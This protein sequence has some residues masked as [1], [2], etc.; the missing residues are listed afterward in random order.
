MKKTNPDFLNGV[1]ELLIL[2][3][4]AGQPMHGYDLVQA[5]RDGSSMKLDFGEGSIYPVL[6]RMEE[7]KLLSSKK[8]LVGG[9]NRIIYRLT[10]TGEKKLESSHA[11]WKQVVEAVNSVMQGMQGGIHGTPGMA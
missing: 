11:A 5:I 4:L 6:H 8:E 2:R 9:R 3:L 7:Q 10:K 1:P